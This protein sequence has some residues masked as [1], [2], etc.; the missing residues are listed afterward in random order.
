M[1]KPSD[2]I[3][4]FFWLFSAWALCWIL[5]LH[6]MPE[7]TG[8]QSFVWWTARKATIWIGLG[9]FL[10][11][12]A[13]A[14][15][16]F[17]TYRGGVALVVFLGFAWLALDALAVS[18]GIMSAP[19]SI[20][21]APALVNVLIVSPLFEEALFRGLFWSR[22][23]KLGARPAA[24]WALSAGAFGSLHWPGWIATQ[25]MS[26]ALATQTILTIAAGLLF[27][28]GRWIT[29]SVWAAMF[30]HLVNNA[31]SVG[32]GWH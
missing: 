14:R 4:R 5:T 18:F 24:V 8:W 13:N 23:E 22:L 9:A 11:H 6:G 2:A 1:K 19:R 25:G 17:G 32:I 30:L 10:F 15:L 27:G 7:L 20:P 16:W 28:A 3:K 12:P 21:P 26:S 29:G 31:L